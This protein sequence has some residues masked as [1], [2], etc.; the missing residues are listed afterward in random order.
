[1]GWFKSKNR[2]LEDKLLELYT[3]FFVSNHGFSRKEAAENARKLLECA[4]QMII[5]T[6]QEIIPPNSA[7]VVLQMEKQNPSFNG[8]DIRRQDG[9][10]DED[11]I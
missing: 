3:N 8:Y 2:E 9:V 11:I 10:K 5:E 4:K 7:N 1:M 6:G